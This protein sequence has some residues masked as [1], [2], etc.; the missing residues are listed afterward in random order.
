MARP[1]STKSS[2]NCWGAHPSVLSVIPQLA[3]RTA[4]NQEDLQRFTILVNYADK[5]LEFAE[6]DF[7]S[8]DPERLPRYLEFLEETGI[9]E[10]LVDGKIK[11]LIDYMIG[12]EA[13]LDSNARKNRS[14][15]SME[16]ICETFIKDWCDAK[17]Y[18]YLSQATIDTAAEAF[19]LSAP[20]ELQGSKRK[21]DFAVNASEGL[22]LF[23][24][25][26]YNGGGSKL[27]K[28]AY[29]YESQHLKLKQAGLGFIWITDGPGWKKTDQPLSQAFKAIDHLFSL[30]M[31]EKGI[32]PAEF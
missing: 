20:A 9:K 8:Y 23:E 5:R 4:K 6:Y 12:V 15:K 1:T 31:L 22:I 16:L 29:D 14:G 24:V 19:G 11:N 18:K 17:G 28:T 10:L 30:D 27:D 26:F 25:N 32:L 21:Y 3:V 13:G 2:N 7:S